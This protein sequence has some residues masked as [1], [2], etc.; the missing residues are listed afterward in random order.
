[1]HDQPVEASYFASPEAAVPLITALLRQ[2]DFKSLAAYYDL[3]NSEIPRACLES[4]SFFIREKRPEVAHPAGFWRHKHPFSPGFEYAGMRASGQPQVQ[5]ITVEISID[6]GEGSPSQVGRSSFY[7]IQ[8]A[9]G[10]Q[11]L[12]E[13]VAEA[14]DRGLPQ[15][16]VPE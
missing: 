12:P 1:M 2:E 11:V 4:G 15:P 9:P 13:P 6:Q 7:M 3:S 5:V 14:D 8:S 16:V 10:W